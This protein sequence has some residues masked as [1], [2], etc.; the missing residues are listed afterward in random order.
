MGYVI[1]PKS[2][3]DFINMEKTD[4]I[5]KKYGLKTIQFNS[6]KATNVKNERR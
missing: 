4:K 5:N 6:M 1:E 2:T 3:K